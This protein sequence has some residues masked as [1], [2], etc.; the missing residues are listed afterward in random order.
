MASTS[1]F[2]LRQ[3]AYRYNIKP[4]ATFRFHRDL[5]RYRDIFRHRL[6]RNSN[7]LILC[8]HHVHSVQSSLLSGC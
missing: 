5:T 3:R 8:T 6:I 2:S 1:P 4:D 7:L